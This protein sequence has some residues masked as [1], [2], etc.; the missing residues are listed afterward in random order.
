M[1]RFA[2]TWG[3]SSSGLVVAGGVFEPDGTNHWTLGCDAVNFASRLACDKG[4]Y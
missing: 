2:I 4:V 1:A 3:V